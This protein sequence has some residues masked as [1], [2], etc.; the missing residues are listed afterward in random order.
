M[1]TMLRPPLFNA[2]H[3]LACGC[4]QNTSSACERREIRSRPTISPRSTASFQE[5][6]VT[7][8]PVTRKA[9]T[10][11]GKKPIDSRRTT[12]GA[13]LVL[14][15]TGDVSDVWNE[16]LC[17]QVQ[18]EVDEWHV[19]LREAQLKREELPEPL[20]DYSKAV[21]AARRVLANM[22]TYMVFDDHEITDDWNL[23]AAW[24]KK[25][26]SDAMARRIIANRARG[27]PG[28]SK[29]GENDPRPVST[30]ALS[31]PLS[32]TST[33]F[34]AAKVHRAARPSVR[35]DAARQ[36]LVVLTPTKPPALCVDTRTRREHPVGKT[37]VLA[38]R[39]SGRA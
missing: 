2:V 21:A 16:E 7:A 31:M 23:D 20:K 15:D 37:V 29:P 26:K 36:A 22:A 13:P 28:L 32:G 39:K 4:V 27:K 18:V 11:F 12:R 3:K 14:P 30:R 5:Y 6:T 8:G 38:D 24:E 1:R 10:S 17:Q 25:T 34:V 33:R 35:S 19:G 9:F